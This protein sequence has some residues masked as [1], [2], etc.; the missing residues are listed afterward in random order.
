MAVW[1]RN[2]PSKARDEVSERSHVEGI[3]FLLSQIIF[4]VQKALFRCLDV[5]LEERLVPCYTSLAL[6]LPSTTRP[7]NGNEMI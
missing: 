7:R 4:Y 2:P 5:A 6:S 3:T 1:R